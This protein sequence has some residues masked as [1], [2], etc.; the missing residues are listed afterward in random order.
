HFDLVHMTL[1]PKVDAPLFIPR[2]EDPTPF[3][4]SERIIYG[5]NPLESVICQFRF[6]AIL[7]ISSEPPVDFQEALRKDFPLFREVPPVNVG[8]G[9]PPELAE[10]IGRLMPLP[11]SKAYELTSENSAWQITLTQD[12]LSLLC[13]SYRR[14]EE[15]KERLQKSLHLLGEIYQPS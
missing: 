11:S 5:K 4:D 13:K 1:Q 6:P 7:K 2:I 12:S 15:F 9:L 10:I 3:P 8:T 14:W